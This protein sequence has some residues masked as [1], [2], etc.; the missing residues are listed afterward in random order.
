M[1]VTL[2]TGS[3][4]S[5]KSHTLILKIQRYK[6]AKKK[7]IV[8]KYDGDN[9][10]DE[11]KVVSHNKVSCPC[12]P[13]N[14]TSLV[15]YVDT[16]MDYDV[17]GIDE[18]QFFPSL[19]EVCTKLADAGKVILVAGLLTTSMMTPFIPTRDLAI[20]ADDIIFNKAVCV[21]CYDDASRSYR[22]DAS[23]SFECIGAADKYEARCRTCF[24]KK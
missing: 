19:V 13:L 22:H 18:G 7:C 3:M 4:F 1:S 14:D 23:K 17:I 12:V 15:E 11:A 6:I 21:N 10:Y 9:R 2:I 24:N 20:V 8:V 5:G 16:L